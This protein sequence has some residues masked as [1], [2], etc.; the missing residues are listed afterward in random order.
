[1]T[2]C[3]PQVVRA[4]VEGQKLSKDSGFPHSLPHFL[5]TGVCDQYPQR[6]RNPELHYLFHLLRTEPSHWIQS[7]S[8]PHGQCGDNSEHPAQ[9]Q[10]ESNLHDPSEE[11][12]GVWAL[13]TPL[14]CYLYKDRGPLLMQ[15]L[16]LGILRRL[17]NLNLL[18]HRLPK[19]DSREHTAVWEG[20]IFP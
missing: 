9:V 4:S 7:S 12:V 14:P 15:T 10:L 20:P 2:E 1:M 19:F 3:G 13:R 18:A 17:L 16:R 8:R 6:T 11:G 5:V